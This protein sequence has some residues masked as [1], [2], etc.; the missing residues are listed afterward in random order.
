MLIEVRTSDGDA[1]RLVVSDH[2][3]GTLEI[4]LYDGRLPKEKVKLRSPI[5][6]HPVPAGS[7]LVES[8]ATPMPR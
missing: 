1:I 7:S 4:E 8:G 2:C 5:L 3:S 6:I